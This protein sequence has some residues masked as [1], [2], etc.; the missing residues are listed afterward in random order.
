MYQ[1]LLI[2]STFCDYFYCFTIIHN[3]L[4]NMPV[5]LNSFSI[6]SIEWSHIRRISG[7]VHFKS[8]C[9]LSSRKT[10]LAFISINLYLMFLFPYI[11]FNPGYYLYFPSLLICYGT[12]KTSHRFYMHLFYWRLSWISLLMFMGYS[13]LLF[14]QWLPVIFIQFAIELYGI[15]LTWE[16]FTVWF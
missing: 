3:S 14:P 1:I 2:Y 4:M 8:L 9:T 12:A 10:V 6:I 13:Y 15:F 5:W 11:L 7:H 16:C